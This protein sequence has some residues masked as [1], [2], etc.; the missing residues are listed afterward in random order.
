[1]RVLL[2]THIFLWW[3]NDIDRLSEHAKSICQDS[4]NTLILSIVSVWE[5]QIKQNLGKLALRP[6]LSDLVE[7]QRKTNG[8]E[9][10]SITLPHV[11]ELETLPRHHKD[12]FDRLLIAQANVEDLNVLT[13]DPMFKQYDVKLI[14]NIFSKT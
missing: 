1:M 4:A 2:D 6:P 13:I 11:L 8:I 9:I 5:M 3:D 10:L 14:D 12:P 7:D